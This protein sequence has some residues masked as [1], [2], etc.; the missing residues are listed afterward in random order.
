M[1]E[2]ELSEME[3]LHP[4][5]KELT[6]RG[7][8]RFKV[9]A[10]LRDMAALSFEARIFEGLRSFERQRELVARGV[11]RTMSS[12]HLADREGFSRAVDIVQRD[13]DPWSTSNAG[14]REFWLT[15]ARMASLHGLESGASWIDKLVG[16]RRVRDESARKK[17]R[18]FVTA[19]DV[20]WK[21]LDY[22]GKMG[23][24]LP[25]VQ[26]VGVPK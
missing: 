7:R 21:P 20:P 2:R 10:I 25:H 18:A 19:T 11:S 26:T 22:S 3:A 16:A 6:L 17:F 4:K 23:W 5:L 14:D 13:D 1:T 8:F 9:A 15:L 24:D 12:N